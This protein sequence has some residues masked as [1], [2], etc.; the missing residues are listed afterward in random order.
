[1]NCRYEETGNKYALKQFNVSIFETI[2]R[3]NPRFPCL[4]RQAVSR[5]PVP[6][7]ARLTPPRKRQPPGNHQSASVIQLAPVPYPASLSAT[8]L[9]GVT[10]TGSNPWRDQ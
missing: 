9:P 2:V 4:R 1:M 6:T 7:I 10:V 8:G 5:V 3:F